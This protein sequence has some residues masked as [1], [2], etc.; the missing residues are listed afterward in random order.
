[1]QTIFKYTLNLGGS[2]IRMPVGAE[3]LSV[4]AQDG[5]ICLWARV[6]TSVREFEDRTFMAF[7]TGDQLP[8]RLDLHYIGT[9]MSQGDRL[10]MHVFENILSN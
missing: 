5:D 9:A 2:P 4:Q 6:D 1:M 8:T 7:G 3:I 10:V